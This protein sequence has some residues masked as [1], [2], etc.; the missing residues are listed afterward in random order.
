MRRQTFAKSLLFCLPLLLLSACSMFSPVQTDSGTTYLL[1][2]TPQPLTKKPQRMVNLLITMPGASSI[3]NTTAIAYTTKPYEIAYFA[4][5]SWAETPPQM[6]QSLLI[7]TLQRTHYFHSV[8]SL[9]SMGNYNYILNTQI[10]QLEQDFS[11]GRKVVRLV[12]RAQ[13]VNSTNNQIIA[14]KEFSVSEVILHADP[15]AGVTATNKAVARALS[16]LAQFCLKVI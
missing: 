7:Q 6:L 11:A 4:K 3:Y 5:N 9:A 12:L 13:I 8:G 16:Q 1:N 14:S 2:K 10:I 15:Y